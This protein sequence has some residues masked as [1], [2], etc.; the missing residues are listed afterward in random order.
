[1]GVDLNKALHDL[2]PNKE[3]K[4]IF[5]DN[6]WWRSNQCTRDETCCMKGENKP[7]PDK[8]GFVECPTTDMCKAKA[9]CDEVGANRKNDGT[10]PVEK[11]GVCLYRE[12]QLPA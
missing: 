11:D 3:H 9:V 12:Q 8:D 1:M 6:S 10:Q 7:A 5:H 2:D 4:F